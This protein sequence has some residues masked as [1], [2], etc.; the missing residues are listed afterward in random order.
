MEK[1]TDTANMH[2]NDE[3]LFLDGIL[4]SHPEVYDALSTGD[5]ELLKTYYL[6][7]MPVPDNILEYRRAL[8][9]KQPGIE[10]RSKAVFDKV[11]KLLNI[12]VFTY[13]THPD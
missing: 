9:L 5:R 11:L 7:G 4:E 13:S 10:V 6:I 3:V 12:G 8:L 2:Y 1:A